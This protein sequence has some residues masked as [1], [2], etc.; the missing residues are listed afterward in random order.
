MKQLKDRSEQ[1][2]KKSDYCPEMAKTKVH[3]QMRT[4]TLS[5]RSCNFL[6]KTMSLLIFVLLN[7]EKLP[8]IDIPSIIIHKQ[9]RSQTICLS[10]SWKKKKKKSLRLF[11]SGKCLR[12]AKKTKQNKNKTALEMDSFSY[13]QSRK[14]EFDKYNIII[15]DNYFCNCW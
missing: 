11:S 10:Q 14:K 1:K 13:N 2:D 7:L 4:V 15:Y 6:K 3:S 8:N 9:E 12:K 5:Y